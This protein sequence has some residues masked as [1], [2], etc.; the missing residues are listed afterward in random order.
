MKKA[1]LR[2]RFRYE[3]DEILSRGTA[4]LILFLVFITS[5][6]II[7]AGIAVIIIEKKWAH[8]SLIYAIWKSFTLSLDPGNL[9]GVEG[10]AGLIFIT[11]IVTLCG[12]FFTST[13]IGIINSGLSNRLDDLHRGSAKIIESNHTVI[14]G[15][16]DSVFTILTEL[17]IAN[18]NKRN[19]CVVL[20]GHE[21]KQVME[22]QI[23]RRVSPS[24]TTR[25]ICRSGDPASTYDLA[26][27]SI[28]TCKSIIVNE[29]DDLQVIRTLL[30]VSNYLSCEEICNTFASS[31]N[32]H[33]AA[34]I[35]E[36][37]N[38][39]VARI[40]GQNF[41]EVLYFNQTISRIMA[42][43]SYQPGLSS[44]YIDLFDF[45]GDEIYIE[46]FPELEGMTFHDAQLAFCK[47]IIIGIKRNDDLKLNPSPEMILDKDDS[48]ILIAADDGVS[49]PDKM[50]TELQYDFI[51]LS[52]NRFRIKSAE[53]LLIL[54]ANSL[55]F[56]VLYELNEFLP[57]GSGITLA[58]N[59]NDVIDEIE[60]AK[61][62]L[63]NL[64]IDIKRTQITSRDALESL[65]NM[66]FNHLLVLSDKRL[67]PDQ[68]DAK[69]LAILLH[70]RDLAKLNNLEFGITSEM[71]DI[72]NQ[73]LAQGTNV[74][75]FVISNNIASLIMTQISENRLLVKM[76]DSLLD[77]DGSEIYLK[78]ANH[79]IHVGQNVNMFTIVHAVS[80]K[81]EVFI[82]YKKVITKPDGQIS[83]S[84]VINPDKYSE[85]CFSD[86]DWLIVLA[87]D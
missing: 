14:L 56:G 32:I 53:K 20:L 77:S 62:N 36:L 27:C 43:V 9:A 39:S 13:L 66:G 72:R 11:A 19:A 67:Q 59:N 80:L 57:K 47:S 61:Q 44:V 52:V 58:S 3:I 42:H 85:V 82:G 83:A 21:E 22:E 37:A 40:A 84:I 70:V 4:Y 63:G 68:A 31:R 48:L 12:I 23:A 24:K 17:Q 51:N 6:V 30:A 35:N 73:E 33:V 38:V 25:I 50:A 15:Y 2:D 41:A 79:Y 78:P 55:L 49:H 5:V 69:T 29:S 18:E 8:G 10:S 60:N 75:D 71:L 76:F 54:G 7:I 81:K 34:S 65:L 45:G 16:N 46:A 87:E 74:T 28:E 26:R 64:E 86:K 1:T